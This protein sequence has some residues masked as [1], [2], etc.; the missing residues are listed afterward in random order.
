M[1]ASGAANVRVVGMLFVEVEVV[2][3]ADGAIQ[4]DAHA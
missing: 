1:A 2:I 4:L 3:I